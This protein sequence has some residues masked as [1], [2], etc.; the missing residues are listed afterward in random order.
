[1]RQE[2]Q[3]ELLDRLVGI[4]VSKPWS[5]AA[6]SMRNPASAYT[7][8]ERFLR[9]QVLL[10]RDRPQFVG[11]T[12][13]CREP[14]DF[15]TTRLGGVPILVIRQADRSLRALVNACRHR[16]APVAS[17]SGRSDGGHMVCPYHGWT[18]DTAGHLL[19]KPGAWG[20]F[21]DLEGSLDLHPR[22][23]A[24]QHGL[25]FVHPAS[26]QGFEVNDV[27]AGAESELADYGFSDY[28]HVETRAHEW[29]MNWKL[30]LDTFAE[31]YHIRFLHQ[32]SIAPHF[33]CDT[34][35]DTFGPHPRAIGLRRSVV[36]QLSSLPRAE[37]RL[38]PHATAQYFLVPNALLV[39][40]LDHV[41]LW[42]ITPIAVDRVSVLT[43]LYAPE[44]PR[45]EKARNYWKKNLDMLMTVTGTEDFPLMEEI[46]RNLASGALPEVVY[47]RIEPALVHLHTSINAVLD[48]ALDTAVD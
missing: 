35:V 10:F 41:E 29:R 37:W 4:D 40:Q 9:E 12:D 30:V 28:V 33:L 16:G 20:G 31:S 48:R 15:L 21:D 3:A 13:D 27:L 36:E 24:E 34:I 8:P 18:Y 26:T 46:Q 39:Y 23:V 22:A 6:A 11:F 5:R 47:G 14:G 32:Q 19:G 25:I 42:R 45:T 43:S 38:L 1:M 44:T 2:R 17:G 7:D